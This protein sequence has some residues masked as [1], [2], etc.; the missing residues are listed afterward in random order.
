MF[1]AP[2]RDV[3]EAAGLF[4]K[5]PRD[6]FYPTIHDAVQSAHMNHE[7]N[8]FRFASDRRC[9]KLGLS[10]P[11][12]CLFH[13]AYEPIFQFSTLKFLGPEFETRQSLSNLQNNRISIH[14]FLKIAIRNKWP[15]G[16]PSLKEGLVDQDFR[17]EWVLIINGVF[18]WGI[19]VSAYFLS[20]Q[21]LSEPAVFAVCLSYTDGRALG[22][23]S[24][25]Y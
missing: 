2:V 24:S 11:K 7:I 1:L 9:E 3:F 12:A 6:R 17:E 16:A 23:E 21:W 10:L 18:W 14:D 5:I 25:L 20:G 13:Q 15:H 4:G 22:R 19:G 8:L